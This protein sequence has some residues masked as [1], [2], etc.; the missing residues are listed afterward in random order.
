M[1][2][3]V[4]VALELCILSWINDDVGALMVFACFLIIFIEQA[5]DGKGSDDNP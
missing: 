1:L 3:S 5:H 2:V 4:L